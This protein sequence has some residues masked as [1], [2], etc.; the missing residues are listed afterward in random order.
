MR[1]NLLPPFNHPASEK[2]G[3]CPNIDQS[4]VEKMKEGCESS[5][6]EAYTL[7][8]KSVASWL[9]KKGVKRQQCEDIIQNTFLALWTNVQKKD[10]ELTCKL[11]TYLISI[12]NNQFLK[13]I[14]KEKRYKYVGSPMFADLPDTSASD[15]SAAYG[16]DTSRVL[17]KEITRNLSSTHRRVLYYYY[18][19]DLSMDEI[20]Q[21]TGMK[22]GDSVK[23]LK[24]KLMRRLRAKL[25][26]EFPEL[27][28]DID[29]L[30][31][32]KSA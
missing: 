1:R 29:Y 25:I 21:R 10:F 22:N 27:V 23:T 7:Y 24:C 3:S 8:S 26:S 4:L 12:A 16:M 30:S 6:V 13:S 11:R 31:N 32:R 20:A 28:D 9:M 5:L 19:E 17:I 2:K 14:E 18:Y 15:N